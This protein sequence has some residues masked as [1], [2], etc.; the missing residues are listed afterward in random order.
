MTGKG[1]AMGLLA[2]KN[3]LKVLVVDDSA[4]VRNLLK[5][6]FEKAGG[7][8][9]QIARNGQEAVDLNLAFQPDVIT[10]DIHMPVVDGL[11]ALAL[12]MK[13]RPVPVVMVSSLTHEGALATLEA[14]ALGAVDF[15]PKPGGTVSGS[16]RTV[17]Q[18]LLEKVR[19]AARARLENPVSANRVASPPATRRRVLSPTKRTR[20]QF[21]P[22]DGEVAGVVLIGV[23]TGGPATLE[24]I[25]PRLPVNFPLPVVVAQHMPRFMTRVFAQRL[26][27]L[28][29][30]EVVEVDAPL[31]LQ[32]G[33]IYVGRGDTDVAIVKRAGQLRVVSRPP[34]PKHL[35]HPS[36]DVLG[37]SALEHVDAARLIG[38][39]LTG[40]G[41]DGAR[42]FAEIKRQGGKTIAQSEESSVVWGMPKELVE[43]DGA[44]R[45]LSPEDIPRELILWAKRMT[46]GEGNAVRYSATASY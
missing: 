39:L 3:R 34:S 6:I 18:Q 28:C 4:L 14:L 41:Y 5:S 43:R 8:D 30:L 38:V 12:I 24:K 27:S 35:W 15:I 16:L 22:A 9:V 44:T 26:N 46:K 23:S 33:M 29:P 13:T 42:A 25:L 2:T 7:F 21:A 19:A 20:T 37:W 1:A 31:S 17:E 40:M 45:V 11:E 36:A 32:G 10:L